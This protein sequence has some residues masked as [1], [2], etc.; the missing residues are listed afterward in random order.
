MNDLLPRDTYGRIAVGL[1]SAL[2][3]P[4]S[5]CVVWWML[6]AYLLGPAPNPKTLTE[7]LFLLF[8]E[9]FFTSLYVVSAGGVLWAIAMPESVERTI[10]R[11]VMKLVL[12]TFCFSLVGMAFVFWALWMGF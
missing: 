11:F 3:L 4:L 10:N 8:V 7:W 12:A 5:G 6:R 1:V 2:F 9:T